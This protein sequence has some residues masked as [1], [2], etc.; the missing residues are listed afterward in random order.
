MRE[1]DVF[2]YTRACKGV[3]PPSLPEVSGNAPTENPCLKHLH[4]LLSEEPSD[5]NADERAR[6]QA[7]GI[8]D[9]EDLER[10]VNDGIKLTLEKAR[11]I[12]LEAQKSKQELTAQGHSL[13]QAHRKCS[14]K[15]QQ[16]N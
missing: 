14:R 16:Q 10:F 5:E 1:G 9:A 4:K 12:M 2:T 13:A 6:L 11:N 8:L 3:G 15:L 7:L